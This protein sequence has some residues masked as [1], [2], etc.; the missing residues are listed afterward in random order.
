MDATAVIFDSPSGQ[1]LSTLTGHSKKVFNFSFALDSVLPF[2]VAL[3]LVCVNPFVGYKR[4]I[5]R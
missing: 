1:I 4:K 5:C 3:S 2:S